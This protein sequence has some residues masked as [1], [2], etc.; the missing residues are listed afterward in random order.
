M[1]S[2]LNAGEPPEFPAAKNRETFSNNTT[3]S[4]RPKTGPMMSMGG[5]KSL[6]GNASTTASSAIKGALFRQY[7][8]SRATS[9][10]Q[11]LP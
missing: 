6:M 2:N 8:H 7:S 11:G 3:Q 10:A 9:V 1:S 4:F 5:A